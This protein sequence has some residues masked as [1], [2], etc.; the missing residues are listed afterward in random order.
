MN[1]G[2]VNIEQQQRRSWTTAVQRLYIDIWVLDDYGK[3]AFTHAKD[4]ATAEEQLV[5]RMRFCEADCQ[6]PSV[7]M[8]GLL[9]F[10]IS[11]RKQKR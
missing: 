6:R 9:V 1:K 2:N 4:R 8:D 5:R 3:K 7:E 10:L 11:F